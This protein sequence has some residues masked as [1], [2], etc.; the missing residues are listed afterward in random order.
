[1]GLIR[2]MGLMGEMSGMGL[3]ILA[4]GFGIELILIG[5]IGLVLVGCFGLV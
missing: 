3:W 5:L 2:L 1:M 4:L